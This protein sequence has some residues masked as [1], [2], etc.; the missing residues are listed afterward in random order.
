VNVPE[1]HDVVE[2]ECRIGQSHAF[3]LDREQRISRDHVK[4]LVDV[5]QPGHRREPVQ[6]ALGLLN[7][8]DVRPGSPYRAR[9]LAE[10]DLNAAVPD[11]EGH[12][13]ELALRLRSACG[14][15]TLCRVTRRGYESRCRNGQYHREFLC[16]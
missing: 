15:G 11:V 14:R 16:A 4:A 10:V 7:P 8:D 2:V 5:R 1:R 12:H 3:T 9:H 13:G 6:I